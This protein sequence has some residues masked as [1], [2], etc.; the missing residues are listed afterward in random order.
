METK[1]FPTE[2][3]FLGSLRASRAIKKSLT[4]KMRHKSCKQICSTDEIKTR[5]RQKNQFQTRK[6]NQVN[7]SML[8]KSLKKNI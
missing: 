1:L 6:E 3:W 2:K 7:H 8:L 4:T 5:S